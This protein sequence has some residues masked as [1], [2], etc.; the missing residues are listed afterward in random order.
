MA[1]FREDLSGLL[2][3]AVLSCIYGA[4]TGLVVAFFRIALQR[5]DHW[6]DLAMQRA[7]DWPVPGLLLSNGSPRAGR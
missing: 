2:P 6:R 1:D 4:A 5:A 3:L 7:H